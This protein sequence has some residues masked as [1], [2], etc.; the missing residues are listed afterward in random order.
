[1]AHKLIT[2]VWVVEAPCKK[3]R[4]H[5]EVDPIAT[6]RNALPKRN[7]ISKQTVLRP[8]NVCLS[9][10]EAEIK[11]KSPF[12]AIVLHS[13]MLLPTASL[14]EQEAWIE[15]LRCHLLPDQMQSAKN[16]L[17][18]YHEEAASLCDLEALQ[19]YLMRLRPW[20]RSSQAFTPE[21]V[22]EIIVEKDNCYKT[23]TSISNSLQRVDGLARFINELKTKGW[24]IAILHPGTRSRCEYDLRL[25][26]LLKLANVVMNG[27]NLMISASPYSSWYEE[28]LDRLAMTPEQCLI[29]ANNPFVLMDG[30]AAGLT[31]L[32]L[33]H[34]SSCFPHSLSFMGQ[35][36]KLPFSSPSSADF[37]INSLKD[38]IENGC[39][40]A[41]EAAPLDA[42][43]ECFARHSDGKLCPA[44]VTSVSSLSDSPVFNVIYR[45]G[46]SE[47]VL[48]HD[49][50]S[51][52]AS[53]TLDDI[54]PKKSE[55]F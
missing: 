31:G 2:K 29:V 43:S 40:H 23:L 42:G 55:E 19:F 16:D 33:R 15:S 28:L 3:K 12:R 38:F 32:Y 5:E 26:H 6:K 34:P 17:A 21:E 22:D 37:S 54:A 27:S 49:L 44:T 47:N 4:L 14:F 24:K 48:A 30:M 51:I 52:S 46:T 7:L 39:W 45:N 10:C 36:T 50:F 8:Q 13:C 1:V 20:L 11:G 53:G 25:A 41:H 35:H 18:P 9:E